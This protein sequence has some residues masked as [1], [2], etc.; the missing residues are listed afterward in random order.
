MWLVGKGTVIQFKFLVK[1]HSLQGEAPKKKVH[2][3]VAGWG[4]AKLEILNLRTCHSFCL[5]SLPYFCPAE[6]GLLDK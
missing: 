5:S 2:G 4:R 1:Q 3:D 6:I